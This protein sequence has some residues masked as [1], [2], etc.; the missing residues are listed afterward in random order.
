MSIG[1]TRSSWRELLDRS[2]RLE[3][4]ANNELNPKRRQQLRS[5]AHDLRQQAAAK[6]RPH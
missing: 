2:A 6:E 3:K 5:L 1:P 4:D